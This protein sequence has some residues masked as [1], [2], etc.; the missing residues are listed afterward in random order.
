MR[1]N[2]K[3]RALA[4][5]TRWFLTRGVP[6]ALATAAALAATTWFVGLVVAGLWP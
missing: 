6:A 2:D 4:A 3:P 1:Q 5:D